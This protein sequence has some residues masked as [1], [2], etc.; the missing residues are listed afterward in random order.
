MGNVTYV[1]GL[2][3][4]RAAYPLGLSRE[5]IVPRADCILMGAGRS[6]TNAETSTIAG[7]RFLEFYLEA[8]NTAS[9]AEI[10]GLSLNLYPDGTG[11]AIG[12]RGYVNPGASTK[13]YVCAVQGQSLQ[14]GGAL[15][16]LWGIWGLASL[17]DGD[18]VGTVSG[19]VAA[20]K[21]SLGVVAGA[22]MPSSGCIHLASGINSAGINA[23]SGFI[24]LREAGAYPMPNLI[25]APDFPIGAHVANTIFANYN[26]ETQVGKFGIRI[27][28]GATPYWIL[29]TDVTPAT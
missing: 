17:G 18:G 10:Y 26:T 3:G 25:Y 2:K 29:C 20:G 11:S 27:V 9:A 16:D 15:T 13:G 21:F 12:V 4:V 19:Q 28:I 6:H 14:N 23:L 24:V 1:R 5:G 8:T 7:S 22:T